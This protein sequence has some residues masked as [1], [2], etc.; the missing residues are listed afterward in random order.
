MKTKR[1]YVL[2]LVL[3]LSLTVTSCWVYQP[4]LA[5]I[6]LIEYKGDMRING[7]VYFN[8]LQ[9]YQDR[10]GYFIFPAVGG[11]SASFSSGLTDRM[12]INTYLDYSLG[13]FFYTHVAV[14]RYEAFRGSVLEGYLGTGFGH[15]TVYINADPA[16]SSIWYLLPF[17]QVNYGWHLGMN[18]DLGMSLKAGAY[19]PLHTEMHTPYD[20]PD[21]PL[22]SPLL[23]PQVFFRVGSNKR[24][25]QVQVGYTHLFNW[26]HGGLTRYHPLSIGVGYSW[27]L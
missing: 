5:D 17:A 25:F 13:S 12:A 16:S 27:T 26:P 8:P 7:S 4:H 23:E 24:K 1:F 22:L 6:P 11:I 14:G 21:V 9:A 20:K 3:L 15:G 18:W 19:T 10:L 2:P